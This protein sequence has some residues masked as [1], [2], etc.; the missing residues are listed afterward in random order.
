METTHV[1]I[2][3]PHFAALVTGENK[4]GDQTEQTCDVQN[5][6]KFEYIHILNTFTKRQLDEIKNLHLKLVVAGHC[7]YRKSLTNIHHGYIYS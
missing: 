6:G 2:Q 4:T 3:A 5:H 1:R 7:Q